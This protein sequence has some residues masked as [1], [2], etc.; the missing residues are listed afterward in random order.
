MIATA[1]QFEQ[2]PP[3]LLEQAGGVTDTGKGADM[4]SVPT[5]TCTKCGETKTL[6]HFGKRSLSKDGLEQRCR[7]CTVMAAR[8]WAQ[9][10]PERV[11]ANWQRWADQ[12]RERMTAKARAYYE[13]HPRDRAKVAENARRYY[14]KD[15]ERNRTL[16]RMNQRVRKARAA[17]LPVFT[18]TAKDMRRLL[19]SPCAVTGCD[20]TDI[21][22]DHII[23]IARGGSHGAGNLQ[24]LCAFHNR[25][26]GARTWMEFRVYLQRR[27]IREASAA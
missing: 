24:P 21:Q 15:V 8:A 22:I 25:S 1:V 11:K 7:P 12:N 13:S 5:K 27:S 23:P 20:R 3:H 6:E 9:S 19:S 14:W 10:N 26:K 4:P 16:R 17:R 18:V 2:G